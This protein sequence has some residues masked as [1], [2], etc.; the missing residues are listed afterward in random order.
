[1]PPTLGT[2]QPVALVE[3]RRS[4]VEIADSK[5]DVIDLHG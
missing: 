1:M 4:V 3:L 5:N 2:R